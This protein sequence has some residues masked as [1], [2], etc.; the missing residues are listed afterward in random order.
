MFDPQG[1]TVHQGSHVWLVIWLVLPMAWLARAQPRLAL[2][3]VFGQLLVT[4]NLLAVPWWIN[5]VG[6]ANAHTGV[7]AVA[8]I[9]YATVVAL[10]QRD[11]HRARRKPVVHAAH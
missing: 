4:L 11:F 3:M 2:I 6:P 1:L 10:N 8:L 7:L 5:G 9:A